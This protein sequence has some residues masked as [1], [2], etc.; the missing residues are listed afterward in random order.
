MK[1]RNTLQ[2][3]KIISILSRSENMI[4]PTA[5][6][7]VDIV[8]AESP[9]IG[10]A[11]IYRTINKLVEDGTLNKL[12]TTDGYH[13]D[14]NTSMHSHFICQKCFK[15][16]DIYDDNYNALIANVASSNNISITHTN[17]VFEGICSS[18]QNF[19]SK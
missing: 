17:I 7:I 4:H 5:K 14:I 18:C 9:S 6:N 16:F 3:E 1:T 8:A 13:Y 15:I 2:K 12:P 19:Q 11:T 10:Q